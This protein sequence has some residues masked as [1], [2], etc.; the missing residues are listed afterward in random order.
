VYHPLFPGTPVRCAFK[1]LDGTS[2]GKPEVCFH[3]FSGYTLENVIH[4]RVQTPLA[5]QFLFELRDK[6][7]N[8]STSIHT[9]TIRLDIGTLKGSPL[10]HLDENVFVIPEKLKIKRPVIFKQRIRQI[11]VS[12]RLWPLTSPAQHPKTVPRAILTCDT[13]RITSGRLADTTSGASSS[14][15]SSSSLVRLVAEAAPRDSRSRRWQGLSR[16]GNAAM[17]GV[18]RAR[19]LDRCSHRS[20]KLCLSPVSFSSA[21]DERGLK[22]LFP[23]NARRSGCNPPFRRHSLLRVALLFNARGCRPAAFMLRNTGCDLFGR[24][25]SYVRA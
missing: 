11:S 8:C 1:V 18:F 12:C 25:K 3:K 9:Q 19:G 21:S 23:I 22:R 6:V 13:P 15:S 7:L 16:G 2:L 4:I 17:S 10:F 14:S 5:I 24:I 20:G